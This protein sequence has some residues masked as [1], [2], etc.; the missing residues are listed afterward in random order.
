MTGG[1][2]IA[3]P[4]PLSGQIE[5][6]FRRR[7]TELP[8]A[9]Q[10]F[11]AVAAAEPTGDPLVVWRAAT[12]L[13]VEAHHATPALDV[14]L[15]EVGVRVRSRH[16]L[17]RLRGVRRGRVGERRSA[18]RLLARAT[19]PEVDPDREAWHRALGSPGPDEDIAI[20]LEQSAGRARLVASP[21]L[22]PCSALGRAHRR[23]C[24]PGRNASSPRRRRTSRPARS[25]S[26]RRSWRRPKP[27]PTTRWA[28]CGRLKRRARGWRFQRKPRTCRYC[29]CAPGAT[30][31]VA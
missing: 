6:A 18:H 24:T 10:R 8:L 5:E 20:V 25:T 29:R 22:R 1:L 15:V 14:V 16:P 17:V 28:A 3:T 11:L 12:D 4:L 2:G 19:D 13:G 26:R 7:V 9:T 27:S 23:S 30:P 31:R 21:P